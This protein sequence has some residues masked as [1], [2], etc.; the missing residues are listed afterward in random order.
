MSWDLVE[1]VSGLLI[2]AAAL[3]AVLNALHGRFLEH[4][5]TLSVYQTEKHTLIAK[6][7]TKYLQ[8]SLSNL[9]ILSILAIGVGLQI[10][11]GFRSLFCDI[12]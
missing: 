1:T 12:C 4:R 5:A 3:Y 2:A 10:I 9:L 8:V 7:R 6:A 11:V